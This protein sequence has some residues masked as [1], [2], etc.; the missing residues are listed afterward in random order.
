MFWLDFIKEGDYNIM[1][2]IIKESKYEK[3]KYKKSVI[4]YITV[5]KLINMKQM[6]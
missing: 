1:Y 4:Y 2:K 5:V 6:L 3:Q